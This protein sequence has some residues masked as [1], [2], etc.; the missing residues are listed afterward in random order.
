MTRPVARGGGRWRSVGV[1][2]LAVALLA[3]CARW[4]WREVRSV[5]DGWSASFP[6]KSQLTERDV[7]VLG[8]SL[9]MRMQATGQGATLFAVGVMH[10]PPEIARDPAQRFALL[11]WIEDGLVRRFALRDLQRTEPALYVPPGRQLL[12]ATAFSARAAVGAER[13]AG[14]IAARLF[15]VDDRLYQVLA[16][17]AEGELPP[18]VEDN[19]LASFR[20]LPR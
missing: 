1:L 6:D 11:A 2:L 20:L 19:F 10:L 18:E 16:L 5:E 15:I 9:P 7:S 17:G 14:T 12:A 8:R 3:A 4:N 13:R